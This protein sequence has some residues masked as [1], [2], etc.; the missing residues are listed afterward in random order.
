MGKQA[1]VVVRDGLAKTEAGSDLGEAGAA[2]HRSVDED[3]T[4][5]PAP[6]IRGGAGIHEQLGRHRRRRHS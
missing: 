3:H 2:I 6:R 4:R 1:R 5:S